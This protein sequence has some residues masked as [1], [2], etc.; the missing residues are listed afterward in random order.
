[1]LA[2][3]VLPWAVWANF[4]ASSCTI[5]HLAS[6]PVILFIPQPPCGLQISVINFLRSQIAAIGPGLWT[7]FVPP[8][9]AFTL[10]TT[11]AWNTSSPPFASSFPGGCLLF[12][13]EVS[14][15][16]HL[17][18]SPSLSTLSKMALP[19]QWSSISASCVFPKLLPRIYNHFVYLFVYLLSLS[20]QVGMS[21][22]WRQG[23]DLFYSHWM[24]HK[25]SIISIS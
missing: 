10:S 2:Y 7:T 16:C 18:N 17:L 14:V 12:N 1:M 9:H 20:S 4:Q 15:K 6:T 19:P 5:L 22:P 13:L 21:I 24:A 23:L 8:T 3:R 11:S 25:K